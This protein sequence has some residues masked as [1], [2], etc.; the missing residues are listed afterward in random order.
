M[1]TKIFRVQGKFMMGQGLK[2]FTKELKAISEDDIREKIYSEFGSKHR[3]GRSKIFIDDIKEI[4]IEE[5]VDPIIK[6]LS[7]R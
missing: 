4:S 7:N 5:S 6:A 2:H 3:I 1:K